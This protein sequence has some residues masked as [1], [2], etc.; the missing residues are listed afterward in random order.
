MNNIAA[1]HPMSPMQT[2]IFGAVV[3][4]VGMNMMLLNRRALRA[5]RQDQ[6]AVLPEVFSPARR[7]VLMYCGW[8]FIACGLLLLLIG[9]VV[10]AGPS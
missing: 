10:A 1:A 8:V 3:L 7:R 6:A 5:M 4:L 2:V 9:L